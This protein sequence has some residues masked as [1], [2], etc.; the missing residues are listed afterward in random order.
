LTLLFGFIDFFFPHKASNLLYIYKN[1]TLHPHQ[2]VLKSILSNRTLN[3][4]RNPGSFKFHCLKTEK[5]TFLV[6]TGQ[7]Q[8]SSV[9][10]E[11]ASNDVRNTKIL[12]RIRKIKCI[13]GHL[14]CLSGTTGLLLVAYFLFPYHETHQI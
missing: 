13:L 14:G 12:E 8:H 4:Q 11:K 1:S 10:Q 6:S 3:A 5:G 9:I 2:S 7:D